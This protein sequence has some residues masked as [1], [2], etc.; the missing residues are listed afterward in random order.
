MPRAPRRYADLDH[1]GREEYRR[2]AARRRTGERYVPKPRLRV[3]NKRNAVKNAANSRKS[4]YGISAE[5]FEEMVDRQKGACAICCRPEPLGVDHC[6]QTG[7][8]R[9]PLCRRCNAGIG[10]L[11][12]DVETVSAALEY[13]KR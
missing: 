13:L 7:E 12:D 8:V 2:E 11:G 4:R 10:M 6:H 5:Q 9:G 3:S 1:L